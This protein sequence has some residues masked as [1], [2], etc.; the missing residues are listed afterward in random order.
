MLTERIA[1]E[2]SDPTTVTLIGAFAELAKHPE[3][4]DKVFEEVIAVDETKLRDLATL[5]HLSAV[6]KET[7]RLYPSLLSGGS[8]KT[9]EQS[10]MIGGNLIPPYTTI[11]A[12]RYTINR[13]ENNRVFFRN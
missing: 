5:P 1:C 2:P 10:V 9:L 3:Q 12:P 7:M 8:R 4:A 6:I 11:V 13:S